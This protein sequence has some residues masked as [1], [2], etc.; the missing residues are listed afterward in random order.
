MCYCVAQ[1]NDQTFKKISLAAAI[2]ADAKQTNLRLF[3]A[4]SRRGACF[5]Y[6]TY[7]SNVNI[8]C[9]M[10][11]YVWSKLLL[12]ICWAV[13]LVIINFEQIRRNP[14]ILYS[15]VDSSLYI[16][17]SRQRLINRLQ[18]QQIDVW[19]FSEWRLFLNAFS[20][21]MRLNCWVRLHYVQLMRTICCSSSDGDDDYGWLRPVATVFHHRTWC[22]F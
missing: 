1:C 17:Y 5:T 12:C 13:E 10:W 3:C 18:R 8:K 9:E 20:A 15:D 16:W 22:A 14:L 4:A 11:I 6:F 2:L 21:T 19:L 7:L